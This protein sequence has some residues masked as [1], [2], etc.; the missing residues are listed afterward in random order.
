MKVIPVFYAHSWDPRDAELTDAME[1]IMNEILA[2]KGIKLLTAK[3]GR[4]PVS[5]SN[6]IQG[7]IQ[8]SCGVFA[9]LP[10]KA[11]GVKDE[12]KYA[13]DIGRPVMLFVEECVPRK[14]LDRRCYKSTDVVWYTRE[15]FYLRV[16]E[17]VNY[18]EGSVPM[19]KASAQKI[20]Q[21]QSLKKFEQTFVKHIKRKF[22]KKKVTIFRNGHG[23][24]SFNCKVEIVS[25]EFS[26]F[27]IGFGIDGIT[28]PKV[29]LDPF[30]TMLAKRMSQ[31]ISDQVFKFTLKKQKYQLKY[32]T[33]NKEVKKIMVTFPEKQFNIGDTIEFSW[34]WS[35]PFLYYDDQEVNE[36]NDGILTF[37][38]PNSPIERVVTTLHIEKGHSLNNQIIEHQVWSDNKLLVTSPVE[39]KG[40]T[41]K[42]DIRN[43]SPGSKYAI[44]FRKEKLQEKYGR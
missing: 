22:V 15:K 7:L 10:R 2:P 25:K 3:R 18:I 39:K 16:V 33:D 23:I 30:A 43:L 20:K 44:S 19:I 29:T 12:I 24:V 21:Q 34:T 8:N 27:L 28:L 5:P 11:Q 32:I 26:G 40:N 4:L 6:K 42:A 37:Q 35:C 38:L 13:M 14:F 36:L 17:I 9:L 1:H 31:K 41:Y